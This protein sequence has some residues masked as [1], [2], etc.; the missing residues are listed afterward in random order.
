MKD[1]VRIYCKN[2]KTFQDVEMGMSLLEIY[3][4]IQ[5]E[6]PVNPVVCAKVN[7]KT[8]SLSF[9]CYL[10]KDVEFLDL[11]DASGMRTYV[12]S[13]CFVLSKA[14]RELYAGI[15]V[16]IEFPISKGYY[17][18]LNLGREITEQDVAQI[19]ERMREI[20]AQDLPFELKSGQTGE[21]VNLFRSHGMEDKAIL[22]E[23]TG[24]VYSSY[25]V[26]GGHID[27]YYG[28]LL[29]STGML[30]VFKIEKYNGG[31]LLRIPNPMAPNELQPYVKQDKMMQ[32]FKQHVNLQKVMGMINVGD[33]NKAHETGRIPTLVKVAEALQEKLIA[34]IAEDIAS[35]YSDGVRIVLISG[36]SSSGKTTFC[37]RLEIQL[38]TNTIQPI[39]ISLDDYYLN[40]ENTPLSENGEYDFE[41]LYAID[42]ELF[43]SDLNKILSG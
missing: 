30:Q 27:Y 28:A 37:K 5:W 29:P 42:L 9:R 24:S 13:L 22:L 16:Y 38:M 39:A 11:K 32:V 31:L 33:L 43:N 7:N 26:L 14:V 8:E 12:R 36:P 25:N 2:T 23:T 6:T 21:I 18:D 17:C 10:S 20:V 40:R 3:R 1:T 19:E 34:K 4:T 35:R 41:S 15:D